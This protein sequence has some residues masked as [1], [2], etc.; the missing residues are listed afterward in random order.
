MRVDERSLMAFASSLYKSILIIRLKD[1]FF[2]MY[3]HIH[4]KHPSRKDIKVIKIL[5]HLKMT[6]IHFHDNSFRRIRR[7][8]GRRRKFEYTVSMKIISKL[9]FFFGNYQIR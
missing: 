9:Y 1:F 4:T 5:N 7:K 3:T 6:L 2:I 8:K